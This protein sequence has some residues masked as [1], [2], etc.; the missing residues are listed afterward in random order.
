MKM[1][2]MAMNDAKRR[3][4]GIEIAGEHV[5]ELEYKMQLND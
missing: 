1:N 3:N 4:E 2:H 5:K